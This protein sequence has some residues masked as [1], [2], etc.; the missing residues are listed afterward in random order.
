MDAATNRVVVKVGTSTLTHEGGTLNFRSFD[1]L[2]RVLSDIQNMG[3]DVI[4]VSNGVYAAGGAVAFD[5]ADE[6]LEGLEDQ[7]IQRGIP[8]AAFDFNPP[9]D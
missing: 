8:V 2:A 1:A 9:G 5:T 7:L 6:A 4:L 3:N